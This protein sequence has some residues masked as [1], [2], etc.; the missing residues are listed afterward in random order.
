MTI[1]YCHWKN[2]KSLG[3]DKK[4]YCVAYSFQNQQRYTNVQ[5]KRAKTVY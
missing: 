5:V 1:L 2:V 3:K 4:S